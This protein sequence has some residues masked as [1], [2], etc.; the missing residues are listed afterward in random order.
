M[1][2]AQRVDERV[3]L[4]VC[5]YAALKM[6]A[7]EPCSH[8]RLMIRAQRVGEKHYS[9]VLRFSRAQNAGD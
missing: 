8:D 7:I 9:K 1:I 3:V 5:D 2:R 4:K 6:R